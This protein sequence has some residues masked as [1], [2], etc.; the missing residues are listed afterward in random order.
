MINQAVLLTGGKATRLGPITRVTNKH[1]LPIYNK[2]MIFHGLEMLASF[3]VERVTIILGGNSVG[4]VVNL[5]QDGSDFGL[6]VTYVYQSKPK[7]ISH[8]IYLAEHTLEMGKFLVLLGDNVFSYTKELN[9]YIREWATSTDSA[10]VVLTDV[11]HPHNYGQPIFDKDNKI[12]DFVEKP[13][14][15]N[16]SF[17]VTGLYGMN[18]KAFS[19]IETQKPSQRGE[20]EIVDTLRFY[21]PDVKAVYFENF[22]SDCGTPEGIL[23]ASENF[24]A[25]Y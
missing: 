10:M 11:E 19:Y 20:L 17:I 22:W 15:S 5:V 9:K 6:K 4:D 23:E 2:P 12:I 18:T 21:L 25:T 1:L 8:A 24:S 16:H 14:K 7:G 3:G 13:E